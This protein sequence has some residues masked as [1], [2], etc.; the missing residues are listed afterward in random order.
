MKSTKPH[1]MAIGTLSVALLAMILWHFSPQTQTMADGRTAVHLSPD[2]RQ[3][4]LGE[5]RRLLMASQEVIKGLAEN[6]LPAVEQAALKVGTK[7]I[8]TVDMKLAPRLPAAFRQL[9][10]GTHRAFD[11]IAQMAKAKQPNQSIQLQ[12][13]KTMNNCISCHAAY[14]LPAFRPQP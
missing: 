5:M 8:T 3:M 7:A 12:L 4:V 2:E 13:V 1:W 11:Q 14:Q 9:G 10:F 6:D